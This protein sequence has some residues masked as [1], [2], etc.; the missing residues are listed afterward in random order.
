[1]R[2][3][4]LLTLTIEKCSS[5]PDLGDRKNEESLLA[6][7]KLFITWLDTEEGSCVCEKSHL[8]KLNLNESA[9]DASTLIGRKNPYRGYT[10]AL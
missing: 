8:D 9:L 2:V 3:F 7:S 4:S 5:F 1:M 10:V 6:H